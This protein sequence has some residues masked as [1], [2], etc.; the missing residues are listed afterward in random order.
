MPPKP[1]AYSSILGQRRNSL[2]KTGKRIEKLNDDAN[3]FLI[4]RVSPF[5]RGK[6]GTPD[7]V[8][9]GTAK[10]GYSAIWDIQQLIV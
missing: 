6:E 4:Q 8:G 3:F 2:Y 10:E 5:G 7:E 9:E 1:A